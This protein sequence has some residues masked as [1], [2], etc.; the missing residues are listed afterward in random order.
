MFN[1]ELHS[2]DEDWLNVNCPDL[3]IKKG[4]DEI[5]IIEGLL[6]FDMVFYGKDKPYVIN[7][8]PEHLDQGIR[9]QDEYGIK[10]ILK[11][12]EH[13]NL[14]QVYEPG[15]RIAAVSKSKNL[16]QEDLHINPN[17]AACLC[18]NYEENNYLP[19]GFNIQ[20]FFNN[21]IIPYFYAQSHFEK[22][23]VWPWGEYSHGI[24]GLIEWYGSQ[25]NFSDI[26]VHS[27]LNKMKKY[28]EWPTYEERLNRKRG[29]KGGHNCVCGSLKKFR[30]CH[31]LIFK[32]L[33]QLRNN[34]NN[35]AQKVRQ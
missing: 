20:D 35:H 4:D 24:M 29:V 1:L 10:I 16:K 19:N 5:P 13:S 17:G 21:L 22:Y 3:N 23:N 27:F 8:A 18:L 28:R 15:G 25:Q 2:G 9:I 14:P 7:P 11:P 6:K 33:W 32:G 34:L 12:S 30:D 31:K 26:E